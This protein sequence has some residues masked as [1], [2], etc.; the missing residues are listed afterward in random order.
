VGHE[1][2]HRLDAPALDA[3]RHVLYYVDQAERTIMKRDRGAKHADPLWSI[4]ADYLR[5][6]YSCAIWLDVSPD[7]ETVLAAFTGG[8]N[9]P[10]LITVST[11]TGKGTEVPLEGDVLRK[12]W[13]RF[14]WKDNV[15]ILLRTAHELMVMDLG[16][17]EL[18]TILRCT[19]D[20]RFALSPDRKTLIA[21]D[22]TST[23]KLYDLASM[24]VSDAFSVKDV[25]GASH[26][27]FALGEKLLYLCRGGSGNSMLGLPDVGGIYALNIKSK[28]IYRVARGPMWI[29]NMTCYQRLP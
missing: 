9:P 16:T 24:T 29:S 6:P 26:E 8:G 14:H 7:G 10:H 25:P 18:K 12:V 5:Q 22:G 4:P 20:E 2:A 28:E 13:N 23:A 19:S 11:K 1:R 3:S 21:I 27:E 17:R 15:S